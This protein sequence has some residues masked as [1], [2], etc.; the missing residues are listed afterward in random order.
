[1]PMSRRNLPLNALRGF[2]VAARHCHLREAALELGVTHG[3]VSRQ[4]R[5]LEETLGV[6][7]FDRSHNRLTLTSAGRRLMAAVGDAFD[8]ITES[9]LSLDPESMA[10]TLVVAATP[11]IIRCANP[12]P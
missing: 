4:I 2:E 11:S 10:G 8:Q 1:M 5:L 6:E 3:A 7:L 9:T 12:G